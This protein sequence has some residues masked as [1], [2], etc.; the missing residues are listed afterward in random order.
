MASM[1]GAPYEDKAMAIDCPHCGI[2][3][4]VAG[5]FESTWGMDTGQNRKTPIKCYACGRA[6]FKPDYATA[7]VLVGN[8]VDSMERKA[9]TRSCL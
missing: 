2:R 7:P 1:D 5:H 8:A 9:N 6:F 3:N 4:E